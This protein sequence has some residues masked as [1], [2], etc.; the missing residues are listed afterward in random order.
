M[1][2][3]VIGMLALLLAQVIYTTP[4][5]GGDY[6]S[7]VYPRM[8]LQ[9]IPTDVRLLNNSQLA[10]PKFGNSSYEFPSQENGYPLRTTSYNQPRI[11]IQE[12]LQMQ[13]IQ[14]EQQRQQLQVS[15][16]Q[17]NQVLAQKQDQYQTSVN[18]Q[19]LQATQQLGQF[20]PKSPDF[21]AKFTEFQKAN[22][23]AFQNPGF[24]QLASQLVQTR[25]QYVHTEQANQHAQD[26]LISRTQL[27]EDMYRERVTN[28][29]KAKAA[30]V[31]LAQEYDDMLSKNP[32]DPIG[33]YSSLS[34]HVNQ[35]KAKREQEKLDAKPMS[36]ENYSAMLIRQRNLTDNGKVDYADLSPEK[37][38]SYDFLE[39][40]IK[41]FE[42]KN[43]TQPASASAP[44]QSVS[45]FLPKPLS[46][47]APKGK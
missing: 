35:E 8:P 37:Q 6:L 4:L 12:Q 43:G 22:P 5:P 13:Q 21:E 9:T 3:V 31:G 17:L 18:N 44:T 28:E 39:Q 2:E 33:A 23:L 36:F 26:S 19:A 30:E 15:G 47:P 42:N 24:R 14:T 10:A 11:P 25:Q 27:Q 1:P 20:D 38:A 29:M 45:Y 46:T 34:G 32:M 16:M 41:S 7:E 40:Q